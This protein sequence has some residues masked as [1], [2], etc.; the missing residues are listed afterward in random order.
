MTLNSRSEVA[1]D[2]PA[3]PSAPSAEPEVTI[4]R[5]ESV[6]RRLQEL[7]AQTPADWSDDL[8]MRQLKVLFV[9]A[10]CEPITIGDIGSSIGMSPAS[11][12]A[13]IDRLVR[14]GLVTRREAAEDRRRKLLEVS[15]R[16]RSIL[17]EHQQRARRRL[18][19]LLA[20]MS[21]AGRQ[22]LAIGLE[23][24]IRAYEASRA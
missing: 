9:I 19:E 1:G 2:R 11:A 16:G 8:T 20:S 3:V 22:A 14:L 21:P 5:V 4:E 13:L 18:R 7:I 10:R 12:S 23:E 6:A 24:M 15:E 17:D